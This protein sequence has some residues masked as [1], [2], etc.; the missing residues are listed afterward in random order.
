[1]RFLLL[2][3]LSFSLLLCLPF[4]LLFHF[5]LSLTRPLFPAKIASLCVSLSMEEYVYTEARNE[6]AAATAAAAKLW[7]PFCGESRGEE[8]TAPSD[9]VCVSCLSLCVCTP[10]CACDAGNHTL[11]L[12]LSCSDAVSAAFVSQ[13]VR[14]W[15]RT[16]ECVCV[17]KIAR[18]LLTRLPPS[19]VPVSLSL[20]L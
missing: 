11:P 17:C 1:M 5:S 7:T 12:T 3:L 8:D 13:C 16:C 18:R 9:A 20:S 6:R 14:G 19:S 10:P 2:L 4:H 15:T